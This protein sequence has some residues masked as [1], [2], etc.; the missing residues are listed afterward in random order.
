MKANIHPEYRS[1]LF[2]DI[3]ADSFFLIGSTIKTDQQHTWE[4]DGQ[5]YPY[6]TL[7]VS[8]DSHPFYT[9]QQKQSSKE[10]RVASFGQRF[11]KLFSKTKG[12]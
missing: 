4:E 8:S 10:G 11:G 1:V 2:H 5:T 12:K 7:D 6:V 9:G 3:S